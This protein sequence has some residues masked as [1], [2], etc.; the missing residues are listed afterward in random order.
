MAKK[1]SQNPPQPAGLIP[2]ETVERSILVIRGENVL[3]DADLAQLYGV[4]TRALT[5]AVRRNLNRFPGDFMFRLS[6]GEFDQLRRCHP[7][8]DAATVV[9][10][11][12]RW[13]RF[14]PGD[15]TVRSIDSDFQ[16]RLA[17]GCG[18]FAEPSNREQ[19]VEGDMR[20]LG[21]GG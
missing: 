6:S 21:Y 15:R 8:T 4:E 5:Q 18:K 17:P 12:G 10:C 3:L 11:Q 9:E 16:C 19:D 7:S 1:R 14:W 2:P 20:G 13:D